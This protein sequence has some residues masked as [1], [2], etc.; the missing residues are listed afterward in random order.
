M[1]LICVVTFS[2]RAFWQKLALALDL[3][4]LFDARLGALGVTAARAFLLELR[5]VERLGALGAAA[6]LVLEPLRER[7]R[8]LLFLGAFGFAADRALLLLLDRLG[9]LGAAAAR[10][11]EPFLERLRDLLAF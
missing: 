8:D 5:L 11:F 6:A 7:L 2:P 4:Q 9:A 1:F 10:A 3:L